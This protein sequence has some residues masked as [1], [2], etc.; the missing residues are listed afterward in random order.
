MCIALDLDQCECEES[1]RACEVCCVLMDGACTSTFVIADD[2]NNQEL[3]MMLPNGTG[4][5]VQ[6]GSPCR[7]FTGN[8]DFLNNCLLVDENGALLRLTDLFFNSPL[9]RRVVT[10]VTEM[11]W[12]VVIAAVVLLVLIFLL[13]L[14][15]HCLLPRPEHVQNRMRRKSLEKNERRR[16]M[17][18]RR[19]Q[20]KFQGGY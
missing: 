11:W 20:N 2:P 16:A 5:H 18:G 12:V 3:A 1:E 13:V 19:D 15:V 8:C 9:F 6:I 10:F 14:L 4:Q 7:N 17:G